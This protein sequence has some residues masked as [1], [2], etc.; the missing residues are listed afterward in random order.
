[1]YFF[2]ICL[3]ELLIKLLIFAQKSLDTSPHADGIPKYFYQ[4]HL[5]LD[6]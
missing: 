5:Q 4:N 6:S 1:M 3:N 2:I